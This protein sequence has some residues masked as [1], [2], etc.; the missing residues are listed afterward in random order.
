[1]EVQGNASA[2]SVYASVRQC[3]LER[4]MR[5]RLQVLSKGVDG[6]GD[7]GASDDD[8]DDNDDEL[9]H[10]PKVFINAMIFKV[11]LWVFC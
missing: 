8:N 2:F 7:D 11:Y 6:K 4:E 9:I 10:L 3:I 1:M 5:E